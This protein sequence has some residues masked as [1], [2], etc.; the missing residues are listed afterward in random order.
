MISISH[1]GMVWFDVHTPVACRHHETNGLYA[2]LEFL[3][4]LL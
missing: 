4:D 1:W 2:W 3:H